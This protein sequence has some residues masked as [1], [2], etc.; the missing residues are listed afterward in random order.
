MARIEHWS[1]DRLIPY[2]RNAQT[3]SDA[4]VAQIVARISEFG[5]NNLLWWIP[6]PASLPDTG[7]C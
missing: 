5:F 6:A 7:G 1:L 2:A 3:H 4:Q